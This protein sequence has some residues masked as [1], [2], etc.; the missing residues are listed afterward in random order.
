MN[1]R[2]SKR[3]GFTLVEMLTVMV[4]IAILASMTVGAVTYAIAYINRTAISVEIKNM[5][6]ALQNYKTKYT[7]YPPDNQNDVYN[8]MRRC[9]KNSDPKFDPTGVNPETALVIFL[10]QRCANPEKPFDPARFNPN[11]TEPLTE[12]CM[13]FDKGRLTG[14]NYT[15]RNCTAPYAYFRSEFT[16]GRGTYSNKTASPGG[17]KPYY[18][19]DAK[20]TDT[21]YG[22]MKYQII[23]A[24][25]DN[26][27]GGTSQLVN[28]ATGADLDNIVS[29]SPM[30]IKDLKD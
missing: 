28:D 2:K 22:D 29:F 13:E 17:A 1:T 20:G 6:M 10:S 8:H 18:F 4:I 7:E 5:E 3:H 25:L 19:K 9:H 23:S 27:F 11:Y 15:P 12:G 14:T 26:Q 21:W 30:T 24:G 16:N